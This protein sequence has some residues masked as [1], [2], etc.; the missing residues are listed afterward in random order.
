MRFLYPCGHTEP[1]KSNLYFTRR[2]HNN[3]GLATFQVLDSHMG[4]EVSML[5]STVLIS[6]L[7]IYLFLITSYSPQWWELNSCPTVIRGCQTH[8]SQYWRGGINSGLFVTY[9]QQPGKRTLHTMPDA[10]GAALG[11]KWIT[12]A[13]RDKLCST[14]RS[15]WPLVPARTC[16]WLVW[17]ILRLA[18]NWNPLSGTSRNC[19][20]S[21]W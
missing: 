4:L 14:K 20:W 15:R 10:K 11:K 9:T 17:V 13:V 3:F 7:F 16:N 18:G 5:D 6:I 21:T 12:R 19:T 8:N 1:S 2:A